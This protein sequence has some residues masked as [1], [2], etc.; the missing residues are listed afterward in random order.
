MTDEEQ[1]HRERMAKKK[2]L[3]DARVAKATEE[4]GVLI[5]LSGPGKGK[6]SS[7]FGTVI[8]CIGHGYKAAVVQFIKGTWD[9]GERNF[10]QQFCPDTPFIVMGSGFTWETQSK[11]QD[12]EAAQQ[13]WQKTKALL[14]DESLHLLLLDELTYM[15]KYGYIDADEVYDALKQRPPEMS[16]IITGR[17]APPALKE[18][19]DTVSMIDDK[20]HAFRDGVKARKGV[21]W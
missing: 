9:C 13:A 12:R 19:A 10:L 1:R 7:G 15:L 3:I 6:S 20:K 4:R 17:G 8:R 14:K 11:A 21:D 5:V 16:V 2:A 18:L